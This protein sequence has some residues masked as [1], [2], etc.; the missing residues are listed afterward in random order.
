MVSE[1]RNPVDISTHSRRLRRPF[2]FSLAPSAH[3]VTVCRRR[4][5][6]EQHKVCRLGQGQ[7]GREGWGEGNAT[8]LRGGVCVTPGGTDTYSFFLRI[9]PGYS[10]FLRVTPDHSGSLR[11]FRITPC[12]SALLRLLR[13]ASC[14]SGLLRGTATYFRERP[15]L[16]LSPYYSGL[17]RVTPYY[18]GSLRITPGHSVCSVLLRVSLRYSG[19]SGFLRVALGYSG[20]TWTAWPARA[21]RLARAARSPL[22]SEVHGCP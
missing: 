14:C 7:A 15:V 3:F 19:Y 13:V 20:A 1:N 9:T 2:P 18:S 8:V 17:L 22:G 5:E 6:F 10:G 21:A 11:L 4:K 12:F 16:F